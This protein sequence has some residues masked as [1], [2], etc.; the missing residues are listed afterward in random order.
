MKIIK[1]IIIL[2][3]ILYSKDCYA[4]EFLYILNDDCIDVLYSDAV[5]YFKKFPNFERVNL[6]LAALPLIL[7]NLCF[8]ILI[9]T[10]IPSSLSHLKYFPD[11]QPR[12]HHH[13]KKYD[14]Y[15]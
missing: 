1:I 5:K 6:R 3:L 14:R 15:S 7:L 10:A 11:N 4:Q 9:N 2:I 12:C 13:H 8:F